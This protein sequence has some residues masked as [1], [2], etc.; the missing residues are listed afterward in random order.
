[1]EKPSIL[2]IESESEEEIEVIKVKIGDKEYL[3]TEEEVL[4]DPESYE[5]VGVYKNGKIDK[6]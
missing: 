2:E 6:L 5:I 3:K 4:L 1:M